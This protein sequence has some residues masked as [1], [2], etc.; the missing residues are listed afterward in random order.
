MKRMIVNLG[1]KFFLRDFNAG[2]FE[3]L[4]GEGYAVTVFD[5]RLIEPEEIV[6]DY[7]DA[8]Q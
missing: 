8:G 3:I 2:D 7:E 1:G 5:D 6:D 4:V